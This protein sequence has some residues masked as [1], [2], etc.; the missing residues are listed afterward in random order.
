MARGL[1]KKRLGWGQED[2]VR[3]KYPDGKEVEIALSIYRKRGFLPPPEL[4]PW[5][6]ESSVRYGDGLPKEAQSQAINLLAQVARGVIANWH[7][8]ATM[9]DT[10]EIAAVLID[11]VPG[12][13]ISVAEFVVR[14]ILLSQTNND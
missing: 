3:I 1:W 9:A 2:S 4:L 10:R 11:K 8:R 7:T 13:S 6:D 5:R 14:E 12:T